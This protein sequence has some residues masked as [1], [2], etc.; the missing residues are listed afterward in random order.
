MKTTKEIYKKILHFIEWIY[1]L[2]PSQSPE[3]S[4]FKGLTLGGI[5]NLYDIYTT[6]EEITYTEIILNFV[7]GYLIFDLALEGMIARIYKY[8]QNTYNKT[9]DNYKKNNEAD[10]NEISVESFYGDENNFITY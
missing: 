8:L 5:K 3:F 9:T 1:K 7:L 4:L 2:D 6:E 10:N